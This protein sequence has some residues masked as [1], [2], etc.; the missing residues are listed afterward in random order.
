M[1]IVF[2]GTPEYV[3]PIV[4]TLHKSFK[5]KSGESPIVAVVTQGPKPIGRK[6]IL[7][8]SP[9][10]VWAHKKRIGVFYDSNKLLKLKHNYDLG[11]L[12]AFGEILPKKVIDL[13]PKGIINIHPSLLPK[14]RGA[15]PIQ[16]AI[17]AGEEKTGITIMKLD[18]LVDHGPIISQVSMPVKNTDTT[19]SLLKA[20]FMKATEIMK[21]VLPAYY[22]GKI[23]PKE[24]KHSE[25]SYTRLIRKNDAFVP[26][27]ALQ[28]ALEGKESTN[29]W[30][31]PFVKDLKLTFS[32]TSID[33]MVRA[34]YPW[35]IAWT[36]VKLEKGA[37]KTKRLKI[38]KT[39]LTENKSLVI[40][41]VQLEGKGVV[42]WDQ[43]SKGYPSVT[44]E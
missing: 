37:K 41:E 35:P 15:S 17:A 30:K 29:E 14:Y 22:Q 11:I 12:V 25:A 42:S 18:H 21:E 43:F 6:K 24:Q 16:G 3:V 5:Q 39:H 28:E 9:V 36:K 4:D 27:K 40:D 8:H 2:F 13:F 44:F 34:M 19:E 26:F 38:I 10:D 7:T 20:G 23:R 33:Q 1:K 31:I 32:S